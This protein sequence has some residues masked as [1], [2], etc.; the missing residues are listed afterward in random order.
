MA[1]IQYFDK[2]KELPQFSTLAENSVFCQSLEIV[3]GNTRASNLCNLYSL[4]GNDK[5][6]VDSSIN[7]I[8]DMPGNIP[9]EEQSSSWI[10]NILNIK[11]QLLLVTKAL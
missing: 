6:E 1:S 10:E 8:S 9:E 11:P 5:N 7:F 4:Y 2:L 3:N